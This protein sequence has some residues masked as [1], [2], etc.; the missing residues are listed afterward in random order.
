M[1]G[2]RTEVSRLVDELRALDFSALPIEQRIGK[3]VEFQVHALPV[4]FKDMTAREY[5][6]VVTQLAVLDASS[7]LS[8]SMHLYTLW[9]I[10]RRQEHKFAGMLDD[11]ATHGRLMGS[12]N[13]PGL[14]FLTPGQ[15]SASTYPV[16]ATRVEG[17]YNVT[18]V[19]KFVSLEPFVSFLPVYC[20]V[21]DY[22]G[23]DLGVIALMLNKSAEGVSVLQDWNSVAMQ[24]TH[25]NSIKFDNAFCPDELAI[26]GEETPIASLSIQGYLFRFNV[27]CVYLGL[28]RQALELAVET[29]NTRRPPNGAA[30]LAKYPG[31][32]FSVAEM[33]ISLEIMESQMRSFCEVLDGFL[34]GEEETGTEINRIS[35]IAKEVI[36]RE[37]ESLVSNAMKITGINS[38]SND[39]PLSTIYK[40]IKAA[41]F[42]PP[43]RDVTCEILAKE[44][45]GVISYKQRWV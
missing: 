25:S 43:Q 23:S 35:L 19:K 41:Q 24:D 30:V 12:L 20:M 38:L 45:L 34:A 1:S 21:E 14:Y 36:S 3:L 13:E 27:C 31:I 11:I 39:N 8:L 4:I 26:C 33:M 15:L 9:G 6:A 18:G 10:S 7:A 5:M 16:K 40:D 44:K 28:A 32:Q 42:H 17:G 2:I 22:A 29:A 37:S